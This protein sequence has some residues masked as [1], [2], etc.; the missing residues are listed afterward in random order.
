MYSGYSSISASWLEKVRAVLRCVSCSGH[1]QATSICAWPKPQSTGA[2]VPFV[3][4]STG[5][6]R[7]RAASAPA[8]SSMR[9][10]STSASSVMSLSAA[11][12]SSTR[13]E[14][15]SSCSRSSQRVFTSIHNW[16]TVSSQM[17]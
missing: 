17:P 7:S 1:S 3:A 15:G 10:A 2:L 16:N 8:S 6:S 11:S 4:A 9:G 14:V 5:R 12:I 13:S